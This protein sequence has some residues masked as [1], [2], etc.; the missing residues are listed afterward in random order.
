MEFEGN[1]HIGPSKPINEHL[2]ELD[3]LTPLSLDAASGMILC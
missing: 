2:D 3:A 1:T